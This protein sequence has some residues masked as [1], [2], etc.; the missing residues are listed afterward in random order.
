MNQANKSVTLSTHLTPQ[1]SPSELR[2][3]VKCLKRLAD[4]PSALDAD[5]WR[6]LEGESLEDA[7]SLL[8]RLRKSEPEPMV[9]VLSL[10]LHKVI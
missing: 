1:L 2:I 10:S 7:M 6:Q 4:S 5:E 8:R 9:D 3:L